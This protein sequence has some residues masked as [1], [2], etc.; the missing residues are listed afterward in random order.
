MNDI[1]SHE[2]P[3]Q[4]Q[5]HDLARKLADAFSATG[6]GSASGHPWLWRALLQLLAQG[7]PVT[8]DDIAEATGHAVTEV[9]HALSV[10]PDTEYDEAGHI[11]GS[12]LT[13]RP[14]PHQFETA[15]RTLY[16]WCALDTLIFPTVLD[17]SA[18]IS[19]PCH[20]TGT[21]IHV[22]V[23][24]TRMV[25]I[26]PSTAV[27]SVVVPDGASSIRTAFCDQV[28]FFVSPT[29]AKPWLEQHPDATVLP[30]ADAFDLARPLTAMLLSAD[31]APGSC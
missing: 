24:P 11:V 1:D 10:L 19:S 2:R 4:P 13:L 12:G 29:A 23:E 28:H 14:T 27:V 21:P 15:G 26:D 3:R 8:E 25:D 30:V 16:T 22:T 18:R 7:E 31:D 9:R 20:A 5:A 17:R 6:S